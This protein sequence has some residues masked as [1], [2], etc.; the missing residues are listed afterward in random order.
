[1]VKGTDMA[2][3][4]FYT[5]DTFRR[6]GAGVLSGLG[7]TGIFR[8]PT[9]LGTSLDGLGDE[10]LGAHIYNVVDRR[11]LPWGLHLRRARPSS[12]HGL[13]ADPAVATCIFNC[14]GMCERDPNCEAA[15]PGTCEG[16]VSSVPPEP[17]ELVPECPTGQVWNPSRESCEVPGYTPPV[18]PMCPTGQKLDPKTNKCVTVGGGG[19]Y[20]PPTTPP[21]KTVPPTYT[22]PTTPP[23]VQPPGGGVMGFLTKPFLGL[24]VIAWFGA[25]AIMVVVGISVATK[26][27][28]AYAGGY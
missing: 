19:G 11:G 6:R 8:G 23:V 15:C 7:E 10:G 13:G 2:Q 17:V 16:L 3:G 1:V 28:P 18:A 25:G 12:L 21:V 9:T 4:I 14:Q 22:P 24:P 5:R 26:R 20:T 27:K